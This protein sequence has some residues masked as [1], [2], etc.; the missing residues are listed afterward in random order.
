MLRWPVL[1]PHKSGRKKRQKTLQSALADSQA[2]FP[3][4][5]QASRNLGAIQGSPFFGRCT[6]VPPWRRGTYCLQYTTM[7][8]GF[9]ATLD[10]SPGP[11]H[12][13]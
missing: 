7:Y 13:H 3:A 5:N 6:L 9:F 11:G 4:L 8:N 10:C 2:H 12:L 1:F